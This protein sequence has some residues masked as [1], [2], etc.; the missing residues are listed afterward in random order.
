MSVGIF[1]GSK[2]G[3]TKAVCEFVASELDAKIFD[4][5][6]T[7]TEEIEKFDVVILASSSYGFGELQDNWKEKIHS[8]LKVDFKDKKV[9]LIGVGNQE[10]HQDSF[11]SSLVDFLP[12]LKK[13]NLIGFDAVS[14]THLTL[15][16]KRIV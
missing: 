6:D 7:K 4:I 14:Y 12:F 10:R 15:P 8:L 3:A 9:A 2:Q 13:T 5:K 11:C 1:Y 16:T